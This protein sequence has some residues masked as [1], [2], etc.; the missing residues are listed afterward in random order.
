MKELKLLYSYDEWKNKTQ[1]IE[2]VSEEA[3]R[4]LTLNLNF[5]RTEEEEKEY[6]ELSEKADC[7]RRLSKYTTLTHEITD[8][9]NQLKYTHCDDTRKEVYESIGRKQCE[10]EIIKEDF[11]K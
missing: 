11:L 6:Q 4:F 3:A 9:Y 8:M 7:R 1:Y 2:G 10:I 5:N